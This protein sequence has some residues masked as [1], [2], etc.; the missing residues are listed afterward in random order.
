VKTTM[1][2]V[3]VARKIYSERYKGAWDVP[4]VGSRQSPPEA[5]SILTLKWTICTVRVIRFCISS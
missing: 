2:A 1:K 4:S 5:N 3:A